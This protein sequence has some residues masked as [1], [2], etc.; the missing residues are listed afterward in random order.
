[1]IN[2]LGFFANSRLPRGPTPALAARVRIECSA[3]RRNF[4]EARLRELTSHFSDTSFGRFTEPGQECPVLH[5]QGIAVG[6][7]FPDRT[8]KRLSKL[9][10]AI[11]AIIRRESGDPLIGREIR[12]GQVRPSGDSVFGVHS[13]NLTPAR[14][15]EGSRKR[16]RAL[17]LAVGV[18]GLCGCGADTLTAPKQAPNGVAKSCSTQ[19][20][21][22]PTNC[23]TS[24]GGGYIYANA[25]GNGSALVSMT[26]PGPAPAGV[27]SGYPGVCPTFYRA[28]V[29]ALLTDDAGAPFTVISSGWFVPTQTTPVGK[30]VYRWPAG[31]WP[32]TDGSGREASISTA[33]AVCNFGPVTPTTWTLNITFYYFIAQTRRLTAGN[34]TGGSGGGG[35]PSCQVEFVTVDIDN[36][37][38]T[39]T[40]SG[41]ATVCS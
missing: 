18:A 27:V 21:S 19:L 22:D 31:W 12:E 36:S 30:G 24:G 3:V 20:Y 33:Y 8:E 29:P 4:L 9:L 37:I 35:S 41:N 1:M 40:W 39:Q 25:T 15:R 26:L 2:P 17:L 38:G 16:G 32:S 5:R 13:E 10:C 11:H 14:R 23:T 28:L 34:T 7:L 6:P